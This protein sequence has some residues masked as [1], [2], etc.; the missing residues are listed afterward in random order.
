MLLSRDG[1]TLWY[2]SGSSQ[3]VAVSRATESVARRIPL[4][5]DPQSLAMTPEGRT[6]YVASQDSNT[7]SVIPVG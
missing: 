2:A 1:K 7:I 3:L 5:S 6:L 4:R